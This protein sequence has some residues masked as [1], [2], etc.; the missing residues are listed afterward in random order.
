MIS[1]KRIKELIEFTLVDENVNDLIV[2][3]LKKFPT[4]EVISE[5]DKFFDISSGKSDINI[6]NKLSDIN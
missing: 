6:L 5:I 1:L 2:L 3:S 4:E